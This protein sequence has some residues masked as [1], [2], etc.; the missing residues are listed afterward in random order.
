[1]AFRSLLKI[2]LVFLCG[3]HAGEVFA[4]S[5]ENLVSAPKGNSASAAAHKL[6]APCFKG[7]S[8]IINEDNDHFFKG[9]PEDM[10]EKGLRDYIAKFYCGKITHMFMCP[11]GQRTS[12]KSEA[13]EAIWECA[14]DAPHRSIWCDNC[15][16]L[17]DSGIDPYAVWIDECRKQK[18]SPWITVRMNDVHF[19]TI[20]GYFRSMDYWR[21]HPELWRVPNKDLRKGGPW[22]DFAFNYAKK[23]VRDFQ[24]SLIKELF[25]RYDFDGIELDWMRF[26]AHLTPGKGMEESE[27]LTRFVGDVRR[28]ADG[29]EKKRGHSIKISVRVP[30][31]IAASKYSGLDAVEWAKLGYVDLIVPSCFFETADFDIPS[32][33]WRKNIAG[34]GKNVQIA[35]AADN[36]VCAYPGQKRSPVDWALLN[37]WASNSYARGA[38]F[39][40]IFNLPYNPAL[41]RQVAEHG[42][43]REDA[44]L[45]ARRHPLTFRDFQERRTRED[46]EIALP[47]SSP[48]KLKIFVG[49]K[50]PEGSTVSVVLGFEREGIA[51]SGLKVR[52]NG[53]ECTSCGKAKL[54]LDNYGTSK[55]ALRFDFPRDSL[56]AGYN[57]IS[58]DSAIAGRIFWAEIAVDFD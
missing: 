28:L 18:I 12:Y 49:G 27:I 7:N 13:H 38:D 53:Q 52:L 42:L 9:R 34:S 54:S 50:A 29:W 10:T 21:N 44:V 11:N 20:P 26:G 55:T 40:Y 56:I 25:E 43:S 24:F 41:F 51:A 5:P 45:R 31:T 32:E 46:M 35:P 8:I 16:R 37:G 33:E 14:P 47:K 30:A 6:E 58:V 23:E 48:C 36:G 57:E 19:V 22:T 17:Y 15:K 2:F 39:L 3:F 4:R 1:M